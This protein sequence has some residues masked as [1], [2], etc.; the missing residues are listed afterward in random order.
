MI[1]TILLFSLLLQASPKMPE[2]AVFQAELKKEIT[3]RRSKPGQ[4]IQ[5]VLG[6]AVAGSDG[7]VVIPAG[8]RLSGKIVNVKKRGKD[9]PATLAILVEKAEWKDGSM[10]LNAVVQQLQAIAAS[11][12]SGFCGPNLNRSGMS[13]CGGATVNLQPP[14]PDCTVS[15]VADGSAITCSKHE[16]ELG[17]GTLFIFRNLPVK[18]STGF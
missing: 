16:L 1:T 17:P 13:A 10:A 18:T 5:F 12:E 2:D 6:T 8:A 3:T 9:E 7:A 15:S 11:A 4:S 14:P